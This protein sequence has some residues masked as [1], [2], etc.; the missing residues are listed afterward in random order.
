MAYSSIE[1]MRRSGDVIGNHPAGVIAHENQA[2]YILKQ[3]KK[4]N[5]T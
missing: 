3:L 2:N 4:N 5:S 1:D